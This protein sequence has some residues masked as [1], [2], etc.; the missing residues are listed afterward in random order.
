MSQNRPLYLGPRLRRLRR[1]LGITQQAMA[2]DLAV[3][4][5]YVALLERNQRPVT[6]EML[7]RLARTYQIDVGELAG[8]DSEAYGKRLG[9]VLRD[10][11][12]ADI[13]VPALELA[14][15]A[16]SFPGLAEALLRLHG[17]FAR[18]QQALAEQRLG[19]SPD[20]AAPD[21]VI[22]AQRFFAA[23]RNHFPGLEVRAEE[24]SAELAEAGGAAE[25]LKRKGVRVR[26]M[27]PDVLVDA[28][29]RFDRHNQQLLLD[30]TL[31]GP[32]RKF[33]LALHI[34]WTH[35]REDISRIVRPAGLST[36]SAEALVRRAL[37]A[38]AAAALVMPYDRFRRA[39]EQRRYDIDALCGLFG[40][41][42]EQVAHRLTTLGRP[43]EE[44]VPFF[45][46][47]VDEAGNVSKRLDG[48]GFPFAGH[49]GGCPLWNVHSTFRSPGQIMTQWLELP[50][51]QRFFSIARTVRGGPDRWDAQP[52]LRS[53]ALA[54]AAEHAPAL[55]Y[56]S[57]ADPAKTPATPIGAA[58]QVCQRAECTARAAPPIGRELGTD[59]QR[60]TAAPYQFVE[61]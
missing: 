43:G 19:G 29:R 16:T 37:A 10:P 18:E 51:G 24:L 6:A 52:V 56:S 27:P 61:G 8:E 32:G 11:L 33:Q 5:S 60:R 22:E 55:A 46:L 2:A 28:V 59:D 26:F 12:L 31:D 58:C 7:L 54:C 25:W 48:A 30:D 13:D 1:E 4:P 34:A 44:G 53:I 45:F 23:Q 9:E 15:I 17:A 50:G 41:S 47:R 57:G 40:T 14:D 3:S 21:P 39:A 35:M 49:G 20:E 38:Y 42:F 36:P